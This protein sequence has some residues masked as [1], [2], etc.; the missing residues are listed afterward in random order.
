MFFGIARPFPLSPPAPALIALIAAACLC[1]SSCRLFEYSPYGVPEEPVREGGPAAVTAAN[2]ARVKALAKSP[3][4]TF[5]VAVLADSHD[6]Y[7][8][9]KSAVA[10]INAD[11]SIAFVLMAGDFTQ[12]GLLL[13]YQWFGNAMSALKVPYLAII[14]NH[15]ALANGAG[16]FR[17]LH[18][19]LNFAFTFGGVRFVCANTNRFDFDFALPDWAWLEGELADAAD[20]LRIFTVS[21]VAP[22]GDQ[23]DAAS[24]A[25][26]SALM[27]RYGV[28][29]S[30]HGHQHNWR[31]EET[32]GDGIPYLVADN[33]G[34]RNYAKVIVTPAGF[35]VERVWF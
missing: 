6:D 20:S 21:H 18:G 29:L 25:K 17:R 28:E 34:D 13:E 1:L 33:V 22:F 4:R 26:W 8:A 5:N 10:H 11:S 19:D 3:G 35:S 31:L 24:A 32:Y 7:D 12:Y 14:G 9:L 23:F 27:V 2:L 15:D 30:I 16:I